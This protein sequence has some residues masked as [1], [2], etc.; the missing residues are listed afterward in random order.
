MKRRNTKVSKSNIIIRTYETDK[1]LIHSEKMNQMLDMMN[2]YLLE[3][4]K[5][6]RLDGDHS[7]TTLA[8]K[9]FLLSMQYIK[10]AE[11]K[12]GNVLGF[13]CYNKSSSYPKTIIWISELFVNKCSRN[14]GIGSKLIR[15][16]FDE[17]QG[18]QF[19]ACCVYERNEA[20][21]KFWNSLGFCTKL[22]STLIADYTEC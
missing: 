15:D 14:N 2:E 7:E 17:Y 22:H 9:E 8:S 3:L 13:T 10:T 5:W 12:S 19:E 4:H 1:H 18:C 6:K 11:T 16:L 20:G 21:K